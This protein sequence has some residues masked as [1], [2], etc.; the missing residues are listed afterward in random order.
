MQC[1][2]RKI[3]SLLIK[4]QQWHLAV[5]VCIWLLFQLLSSLYFGAITSFDSALYIENARNLLLGK[6]PEEREFFYVSY[7]LVLAGLLVCQVDT[8]WIVLVQVLMAL[9]ALVALYRL[10]KRFAEN[11]LT[12]FF[13]TFLYVLWFKFYQWNLIVYTDGLFTSMVIV[14]VY[15]W[16][17]ADTKP[18]YAMALACIF[19]TVFIRPVGLVF[20]IAFFAYVLIGLKIPPRFKKISYLTFFCGAVVLLNNTLLHFIPS[21]LASYAKAEVIYP[22]IAIWIKPPHQVHFPEKE[23]F[24]LLR[25]LLFIAYQP[26]YVLQLTALKLLLFLGHIK[27]YYS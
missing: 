5:L 22:D 26:W 3:A 7:S 18:K 12:P 8:L 4:Y 24:A 13:A 10:T 23:Y 6:L 17:G 27:P 9:L 21:I 16:V 20:L 2:L 1:F 15:A 11:S 25:W 14:S 19:F